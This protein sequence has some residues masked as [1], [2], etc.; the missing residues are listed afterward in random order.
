MPQRKKTIKID[1]INI[2]V[3]EIRPRDVLEIF[4]YENTDEKDKVTA[5]EL[6]TFLVKCTDLTLDQISELYPSDLGIVINAFKEVNK[7]FLAQ[8]PSL[9]EM[10]SKLGLVDFII[11]MIED[12]GMKNAISKKIMKDWNELAVSLLKEDT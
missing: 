9:K 3:Y 10:I 11:K 12:S 8:W 6:N 5:G 1:D 4:G 2:T 7:S